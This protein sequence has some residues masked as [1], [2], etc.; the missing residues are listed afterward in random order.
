MVN[1][2]FD[3][4]IFK[5]YTQSNLIKKMSLLFIASRLEQNEIRDLKRIFGAFDKEKNGQISFE[6]LKQGILQK[7][8]IFPMIKKF[9]NYLNW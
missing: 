2:N 3:P 6:E 4:I 1:L 7:H 5:D 9:L 8:L